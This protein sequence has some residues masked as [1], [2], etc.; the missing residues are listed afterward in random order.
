[1]AS[2]LTPVDMSWLMDEC[3]TYRSGMSVVDAEEED[4]DGHQLGSEADGR[5]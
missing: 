4:E 3:G 1:M 2:F 5:G